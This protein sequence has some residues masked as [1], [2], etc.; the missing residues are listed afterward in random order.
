VR[1]V[2]N[3]VRPT[4]KLGMDRRRFRLVDGMILVAAVAVGLVLTQ[5]IG[6]ATD[7][8]ISWPS[9]FE[10]WRSFTQLRATQGPPWPGGGLYLTEVGFKLMALALPFLA[11]LTPAFLAI[12][13]REPR[14]RLRRLSSQ[15]GFIGVCATIVAIAFVLIDALVLLLARGRE[16]AFL[17]LGSL[18][19]ILLLPMLISL[20][21]SSSWVTL[22]L[23]GR[24]RAEP[25]WIDRLGRI[26]ATFWIILGFALAGL[27][28]HQSWYAPASGGRSGQ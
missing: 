5:L 17:D 3:P 19:V 27:Y 15:P 2:K 20:A 21:I 8:M 14:P 11:A 25:N 23:G 1:F 24:W 28:L 7:G 12:R 26:T 9:S 18:D 16:D 22:L 13:L 6:R 4:P 10:S